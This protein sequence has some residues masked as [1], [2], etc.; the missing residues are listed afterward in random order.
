MGAEGELGGGWAVHGWEVGLFVAF[1]RCEFPFGVISRL[2]DRFFYALSFIIT[3]RMEKL[4]ISLIAW[5]YFLSFLQNNRFAAKE[6]IIKAHPHRRL[7]FH[8]IIIKSGSGATATDG[9]RPI[10][11]KQQQNQDEELSLTRRL[12]P[13]AEGEGDTTIDRGNGSG[14]PTAIVKGVEYD[15]VALVSISHD[16]EYATAVCLGF[17]HEGAGG[18][19][20]NSLRHDTV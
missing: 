19:G 8:D 16:G 7:T 18:G 9:D 5:F 3:Y 6:A 4:D 17:R 15:Q 2:I 11:G 13:D 10:L 20:D 1:M 12:E 14:A